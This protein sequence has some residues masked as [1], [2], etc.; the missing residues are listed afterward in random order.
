MIK[1]I[2]EDKN[3]NVRLSSK[4]LGILSRKPSGLVERERTK[5]WIHFDLVDKDSKGNYIKNGEKVKAIELGEGNLSF[6]PQHP[7]VDNDFIYGHIMMELTHG[8]YSGIDVNAVHI[9][10]ETEE[11]DRIRVTYNA[12]KI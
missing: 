12:L 7:I 9:K 11:S 2:P 1:E 6:Q 4:L 5:Q 3:L 10:R 8:R